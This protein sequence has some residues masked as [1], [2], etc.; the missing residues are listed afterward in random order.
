MTDARRTELSAV[1]T[2]ICAE[3]GA[4]L[5]TA[6][7]AWLLTMAERYETLPEAEQ[8]ALADFLLTEPSSDTVQ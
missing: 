5:T 8:E 7:R 4:E 1:L 3:L 2:L 6:D